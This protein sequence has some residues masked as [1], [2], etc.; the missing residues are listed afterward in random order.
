MWKSI[1]LRMARDEVTTETEPTPQRRR[2]WPAFV[3]LFLVLLSALFFYH[4]RSQQM[5]VYNRPLSKLEARFAGDWISDD[6]KFVRT[7][8]ADRT[9]TTSNKQ[10]VGHWR[11]DDGQL[12]V[13]YWQSYR[14]RRAFNIDAVVNTFRRRR[15]VTLTYAMTLSEDG[16]Q[17]VLD[18][19]AKNGRPAS[20]LKFVRASSFDKKKK[21][22]Q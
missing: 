4:V 16:Q 11:I 20:E 19:P 5:S 13:T 6:P 10:F 8:A 15:K 3:G 9:F 14:T 7:F 22:G 1:E 12:N 2:K 21:N 17:A 18:I